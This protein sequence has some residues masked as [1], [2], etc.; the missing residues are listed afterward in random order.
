MDRNQ[1]LNLIKMLT[2]IY[3]RTS[4]F[5]EEENGAMRREIFI[6]ILL[7]L[8]AETMKEVIE[9]EIEY[10]KFCPTPAELSAS[11]KVAARNK[12]YRNQE[13]TNDNCSICHGKGYII[14]ERSISGVPG[15]SEYMLHCE[16]VAA[17]KWKYDGRTIAND[18]SDFYIKSVEFRLEKEPVDI[19]DEWKGKGNKIKD[20]VGNIGN[21]G[22]GR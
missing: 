6:K 5:A 1:A 15:I 2:V 7:P 22:K 20:F 14:E 17:N 13:R 10:N 12:A 21:G 16:C 11:Y 4:L 8:D 18:K 9:K 19:P 3:P